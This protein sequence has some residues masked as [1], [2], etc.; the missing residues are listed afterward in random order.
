MKKHFKIF[1]LIAILFFVLLI[2]L[3][4]VSHAEEFGI[5]EET[6]VSDNDEIKENLE[7][8]VEEGTSVLDFEPVAEILSE[9]EA[10]LS[11]TVDNSDVVEAIMDVKHTLDVMVSHNDYSE[12]ESEDE[13]RNSSFFVSRFEYEI[14]QSFNRLEILLVC[15]LGMLFVMLFAGRRRKNGNT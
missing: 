10:V 9:N 4:S 15:V 1:V 5:T 6:N 11:D 8:D 13:F 7:T 12:H 14:L 3:S 2:A